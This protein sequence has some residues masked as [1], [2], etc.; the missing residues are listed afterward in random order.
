MSQVQFRIGNFGPLLFTSFINDLRDRVKNECR[1]Y[2]DDNKLIGVIEKEEDLIE[3][4][5][6]IDKLQEL[7]KI[8]KFHLTMIMSYKNM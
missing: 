2:A 5:K 6:V 4:Q 1:V 7:R 8:G 3:I